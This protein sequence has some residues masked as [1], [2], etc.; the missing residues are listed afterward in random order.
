MK[1]SLPERPE[2][3]IPQLKEMEFGAMKGNNTIPSLS[4]VCRQKLSS[5]RVVFWPNVGDYR[6]ARGVFPQNPAAKYKDLFMT[7]IVVKL[8]KSALGCDL[9]SGSHP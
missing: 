7:A 5:N 3:I 2:F 8:P 4:P 1:L 9:Q 6:F